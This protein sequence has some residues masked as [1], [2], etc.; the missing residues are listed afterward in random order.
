MEQE[1]IWNKYAIQKVA[2][3]MERMQPTQIYNE[4]GACIVRTGSFKGVHESEIIRLIA[5]YRSSEE[6]ELQE[7]AKE[8]E[9]TPF[10]KDMLTKLRD[11]D[12]Q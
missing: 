5:V 3:M 2:D 7:E 4:E 8:I 6:V 9:M 12:K 1:C 11:Y 10:I